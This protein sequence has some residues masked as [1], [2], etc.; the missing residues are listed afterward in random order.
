MTSTLPVQVANVVIGRLNGQAV[1]ADPMFIRNFLAPLIERTGGQTAETN[2]ELADNTA[3]LQLVVNGIESDVSGLQSQLYDAAQS[4]I[5]VFVPV[6]E[7]P[8]ARISQ[9]EALVASLA[10]EIDALKK[11]T[12][13]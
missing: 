4:R 13:L 12:V 9:L 2:I 6:T 5:D 3:A 8:D 7:D 11:G 10:N 1:I